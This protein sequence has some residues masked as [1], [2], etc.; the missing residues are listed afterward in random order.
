MK[1]F[2][3]VGRGSVKRDL[4]QPN[5]K[6]FSVFCAYFFAWWLVANFFTFDAKLCTATVINKQNQSCRCGPILSMPGI[7]LQPADAVSTFIVHEESA[8][9]NA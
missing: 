5:C 7:E 4:T 9:K 6:P 2:S 1:I 3:Y 8:K